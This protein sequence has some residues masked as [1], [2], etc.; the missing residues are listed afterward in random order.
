MDIIPIQASA[1]PCERV[2]SSAKDTMSARWNWISEKLMEALQVLKFS[3][4]NGRPLSFTAG[5]SYAEEIAEMEPSDDEPE[6]GND[7]LQENDHS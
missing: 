2:F 4:R 1:V 7:E 3:A 6:E 5:L